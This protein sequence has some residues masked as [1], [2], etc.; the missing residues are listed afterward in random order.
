M[1][2][3]NNISAVQERGSSAGPIIGGIIIL[4]VIVF[5]ALY[6]MGQRE[7]NQ[8]INDEINA[9]NSQSDSDTAAAI[10]ADL[11]STEIENLDAELNAS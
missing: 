4:A 11:N 6:F 3:S 5:G 2:E 9:I 7:D 10:E 1:D 8:A